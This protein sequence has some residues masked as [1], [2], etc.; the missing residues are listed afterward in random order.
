MKAKAQVQMSPADGRV[1]GTIPD[2]ELVSSSLLK[3]VKMIGKMKRELTA[4]A[5]DPG[6]ETRSASDSMFFCEI[7]DIRD[8]IHSS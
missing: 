3:A 6:A 1:I 4:E 8:A 5:F 7:S 2:S